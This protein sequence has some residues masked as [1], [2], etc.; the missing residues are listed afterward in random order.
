MT[1]C[2]ACNQ[3]FHSTDGCTWQ[4]VEI[5]GELYSREGVYAFGK[6]Y[7]QTTNVEGLRC[8]DCG[9]SLGS[10]HHFGCTLEK[11]PRCLEALSTCACD[12]VHVRY[13]KK[14]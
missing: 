1:R 10:V 12:E 2:E 11:C 5:E 4:Y 14:N 9:V 13:E 6:E 3:E 7:K 8:D